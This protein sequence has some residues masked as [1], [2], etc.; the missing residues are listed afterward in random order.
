MDI[1]ELKVDDLEQ[2]YGWLV[3]EKQLNR[4]DLR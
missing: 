3:R 1:L 2:I 4:T